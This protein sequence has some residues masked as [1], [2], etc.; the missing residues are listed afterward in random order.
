[1]K[2]AR[3]SVTQ[4]G[5]RSWR[6]TVRIDGTRH[7]KTVHAD[8]RAEAEDAL[9]DFR[10]ELRDE[11]VPDRDPTIAEAWEDWLRVVQGRVKA[12]T[13]TRYEQLGRLHV[14]PVIG[15][16]KRRKLPVGDIQRVVDKVMATRSP[17]TALHV[18][19]VLSAFLS[20]LRLLLL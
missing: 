10:R 5:R 18:F 7:R 20:D 8:T 3:G 4:R 6:L 17:R 1:M 19:R 13:A 14:L 11:G 15:G 16:V 2:A 9:L 12:R